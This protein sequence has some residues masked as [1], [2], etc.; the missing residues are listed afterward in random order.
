MRG[1]HMKGWKSLGK[2]FRGQF[3]CFFTPA[4]FS[5]REEGFCSCV[6]RIVVALVFDTT[7]SKKF[8]DSRYS[9]LSPPFFACYWD[10]YHRK[11]VVSYQSEG[12]CF[13]LSAYGPLLF[14]RCVISCHLAP[15]PISLLTPSSLPAAAVLALGLHWGLLIKVSSSD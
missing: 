14:R 2:E 4:L 15:A 1:V 11:C 8:L 12:F 7:L 10:P 3:P 6:I 13:P 9:G 5:R